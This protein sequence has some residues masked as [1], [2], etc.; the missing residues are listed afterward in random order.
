MKLRQPMKLFLKAIL[1]E[2]D[3]EV[4]LGDG[5]MY[6]VENVF[7]DSGYSEVADK[8]GVGLTEAMNNLFKW[9]KDENPYLKLMDEMDKSVV[10]ELTKYVSTHIATFRPSLTKDGRW[11]E[12]YQFKKV[13]LCLVAATAIDLMDELQY[14]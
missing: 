7:S 4:P 3:R 8:F 9:S 12:E 6:L 13:F 2:I 10:Q 11:G 5:A 1:Y 14:E